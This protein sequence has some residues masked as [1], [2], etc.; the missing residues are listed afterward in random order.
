MAEHLNGFAHPP[1]LTRPRGAG[2]A[3]R[4]SARGG[5][6]RAVLRAGDTAAGEPMSVRMTAAGRCGWV[7]DR[8]GYRYAD[9]HPSGVAWPPIPARVLA[10]WRARDRARRATRTAAWSTSTA[11]ARAWA[12][13][14]TATR[15]TSRW[16]V[17]SISLGDDALFRMG[18]TERTAPDASRLA[19]IG[20]RAW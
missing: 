4:G 2:R 17:L 19:A 12:C 5:R 11:K 15:A 13:T 16:P 20:R 9:R 14:R 6:R 3:G 7:T 1:G 10:L 8:R 18:G